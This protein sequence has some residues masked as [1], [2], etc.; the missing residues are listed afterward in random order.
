M[1]QKKGHG[2]VINVCQIPFK[3]DL[4]C[5]CYRQRASFL[6]KDF[7]ASL[8]LTTWEIK[9][10][11]CWK[12]SLLCLISYLRSPVWPLLLH[13]KESKTVLDSGFHAVDS[14]F[15]VL[16]SKLFQLYLDSRISIVS[17]IPQIPWA[18]FRIP[19]PKI[20]DSL[21]GATSCLTANCMG[22]F[23]SSA[24]QKLLKTFLWRRFCWRK[25]TV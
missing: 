9:I 7:G 23:T 15:W 4:F 21:H 13:I 17:G 19:K 10:R 14:G 6:Y 24:K 1:Y 20:P 8:H 16:D 12:M 25:R 5:L 18:V 22:N 11:S 3:F 2:H